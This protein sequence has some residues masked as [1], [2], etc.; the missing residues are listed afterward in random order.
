MGDLSKGVLIFLGFILAI[1]CLALFSA[2]TIATLWG[3]FV[4]PLGVIPLSYAQAYG[5]SLL[6]SVLLGARGVDTE[7]GKTT[8]GV[9]ITINILAL[10]FGYVAVSFM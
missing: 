5:I 4:V 3:W 7:K 6:A 9:A 8:V 10:L 2:F 1:F